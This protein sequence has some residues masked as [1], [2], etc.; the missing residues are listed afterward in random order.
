MARPR[1]FDEERALEAARDAFWEHGYEGTSTRD[2]VK[3]TGMTQPSLYNAFGDKRA[4]FRR[5]LEHYL[6]HTL[7][8]RL[9]RLEHEF[10]PALAITAYFAEIIQRSGS[11]IGQRGCMMVNAILEKDQHADGLQEAIAN[12]LAEI[13]G[14]FLRSIVAAQK[15]R[16]MPKGVSAADA[17][18]HLLTLLLGMRVIARIGPDLKLLRSAVEVSLATLGLP[19]L[20]QVKTARPNK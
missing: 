7:R 13:R 17:S 1:E 11:D 4:L 12:E 5:A 16:E 20:Q 15:R 9:E 3:Y 2:L 8:S 19:S 18:A 6:D 14:F 10:T